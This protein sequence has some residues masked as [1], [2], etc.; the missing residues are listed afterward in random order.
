VHEWSLVQ[1]LVEAV[2]REVRAHGASSVDRVWVRI[3]ALAG[4]EVPLLRTAYASFRAGTCCADAELEIRTVPAR[5]SCPR[6]RRDRPEGAGLRCTG[7]GGPARLESGDEIV[8]DRI[9]MEIPSPMDAAAPA[10]RGEVS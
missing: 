3:G 8:L 6:C 5:W 2:E 4:V 9:E 7:C 1:S 10:A